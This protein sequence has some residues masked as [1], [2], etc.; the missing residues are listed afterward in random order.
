MFSQRRA[1]RRWN[2][3]RISK[4]LA[5]FI[6][7]WGIVAWLLARTLIV[8][9]G[10]DSADAIVVLSGSSAYIERTQKAAELY[11]QGRAPVVLLTNDQMRGGWSSTLQ[12]NPYFVERATDELINAG[13]PPD[14]IKIVPGLAASTRDEAL[15][16]RD[17]SIAQGLRSIL[18][19]TSAYH[20][21]RALRTVRQSFSDTRTHV[22]IDPAPVGGN[23]PSTIF[24]WLRVE[25]WRTVGSEYVKLI[26]YW[27]KYG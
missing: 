22:G 5:L 21:R 13:V 12:R 17:Y 4:G 23:T 6:V 18:L 9:A 1:M 24:W 7:I 25:G 26:Y 20:S 10:L 16:L 15:L 19:V 3:W 8:N 2:F 14:R 27:V 11:R